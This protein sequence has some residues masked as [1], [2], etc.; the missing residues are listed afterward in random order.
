MGPLVHLA[1]GALL[2][3]GIFA[4]TRDAGVA[5]WGAAAAVASD[6]DHPL[7]YAM[8]CLTRKQRPKK[9]EFFSGEYFVTKGTIVVCFHALEYEALLVIAAMLALASHSPS[10]PALGAFALGYGM[11][12]ALD[13]IGND[14]GLAGY[15]LIHR[16]RVGFSEKNLCHQCRGVE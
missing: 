13:A 9:S 2:G 3:A 11:H 12:L 7:E 15:S 6:L 4:V 10:A 8:Y 1:S 14:I 16:I 5:S